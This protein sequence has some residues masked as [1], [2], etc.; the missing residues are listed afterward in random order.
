MLFERNN[1]RG[2]WCAAL[3]IKLQEQIN[4]CPDFYAYGDEIERLIKTLG[5]R[6]GTSG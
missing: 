5:L 2:F 4:S 1:G 6:T 3:K